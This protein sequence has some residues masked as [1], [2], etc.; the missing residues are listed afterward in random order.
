MVCGDDECHVLRRSFSP[1]RSIE[2]LIAKKYVLP[3]FSNIM[4]TG[5]KYYFIVDAGIPNIK[6]K[7]PLMVRVGDQTRK[8]L[9]QQ[10]Q[11]LGGVAPGVRKR[12]VARGQDI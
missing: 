7:Y 4:N 2:S 12:C 10:G 6:R 3:V 5:M 8:I 9:L 1:P 11:H